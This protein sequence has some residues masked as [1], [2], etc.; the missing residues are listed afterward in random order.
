MVG[1]VNL[2]E[3]RVSMFFQVNDRSLGVCTCRTSNSYYFLQT[4]F[5]VI[6]HW[7]YYRLQA[8][9]KFSK[10]S[11]LILLFML[12]IC[13]FVLT[14]SICVWWVFFIL[15]RY[16]LCVFSL[17]E[18][19]VVKLLISFKCVLV[20]RLTLSNKKSSDINKLVFPR[21]WTHC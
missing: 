14:S 18:M 20:I 8:L 10:R 19:K 11:V 16:L 3:W 5:I 21:L 2:N 9:C 13:L 15:T 7:G 4:T 1:T 6:A 17:K 12:E